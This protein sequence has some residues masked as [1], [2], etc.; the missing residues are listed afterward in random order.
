M[1]WVSIPILVMAFSRINQKVRALRNTYPA[2]AFY[3][4]CAV[5][6]LH[7]GWTQSKTNL[8]GHE[9]LFVDRFAWGALYAGLYAWGHPVVFYCLLQQFEL[10]CRKAL[11]TNYKPNDDPN[12]LKILDV[13]HKNI[14]NFPNAITIID[15]ERMKLS[16]DELISR[17]MRYN[18]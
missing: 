4:S 11:D 16:V 3:A 6:G 12:I 7:R 2:K 10:G 14:Y 17:A 5:A 13:A 8:H 18:I 1:I 9:R 15:D